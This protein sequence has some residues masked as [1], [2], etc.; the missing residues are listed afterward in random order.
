[1]HLTLQRTPSDDQGTLGTLS[2][3]GLSLYSLELPWRGNQRQVSCVPPGQ[4]TC[5][6]YSSSRFK[7]V[8]ILQ[9]VLGRSAILVHV[10]NWAGDISK[11]Y[12]SNSQGCVL[13]GCSAGAAQGQKAVLNSATAMRRLRE[14]VGNNS[15]LL[16][17]VGGENGC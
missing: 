14:Y 2:A 11:G 17:I 7:G 9:G 3:P 12:R 13:V 10:G 6:P 5:K 8:Y 15:F 4:Y 16:S 1:M